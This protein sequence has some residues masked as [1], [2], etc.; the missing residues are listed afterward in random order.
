MDVSFPAIRSPA[1]DLTW[2]IAPAIVSLLSV[3]AALAGTWPLDDTPAW[4]FLLLVVGVDVAHVWAS[5]YRVYLD[6]V[7]RRRRPALYIGTPLAAL[8]SS[9]LLVAVD[10]AVFWTALAYVAV[11]HFVKQQIGFVALYRVAAGERDPWIRRLDEL[12][13]AVGTL[14]PVVDWHA[15]VRHFAWF[16]PGDFVTGVPAWLPT[17]LWPVYGLVGALWLASRLV[18]Y[19]RPAAARGARRNPGKDLTVLATWATWFVGI[20]ALDSDFSFTVTNVLLHGVPY[21]ALT[22]HTCERLPEAERPNRPVV[23]FV[24]RY[25]AAFVALLVLIAY[26]E[27][28]LWDGLVW[29]DNPELFAFASEW[30]PTSRMSAAIATA[31]LAAPQ[32]THYLLDGY[33][34]RLDGTNPGLR[35][36]LF[37]A[38][39]A[40]PR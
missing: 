25:A 32:L 28:W 15:H 23:A 1:F 16:V 39:T 6:P 4:A 34:W 26:V 5:L 33:I 17:L 38:A 40:H 30:L 18:A 31:F 9:L 21:M 19:L 20:V 37:G 3:L 36:R 35:E 13:I 7:E 8:G 11:Y 12:V 10:P 24:G 2:F 29:H 14:V 22:W 27:E